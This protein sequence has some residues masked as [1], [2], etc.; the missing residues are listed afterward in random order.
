MGLRD[1]SRKVKYSDTADS[2][3]GLIAGR[4]NH[5]MNLDQPEIPDSGC[6][7]G[8]GEGA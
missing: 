3:R 7:R 6:A 8:K 4:Y 2:D 1:D 5:F